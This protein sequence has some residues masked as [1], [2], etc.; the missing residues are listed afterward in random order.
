MQALYDQGGS[1][2]EKD[3]CVAHL[4]VMFSCPVPPPQVEHAEHQ[5]ACAG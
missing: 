1:K 5:Y 4:T 2:E 3:I